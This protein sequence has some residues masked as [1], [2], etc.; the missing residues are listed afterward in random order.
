[1][2]ALQDGLVTEEQITEAC[3]RVFTTR[4]LL[5]MFDGSEYDAIPYTEVESPAHLA[6]AEKAAQESFVLLKNNGILP[7]EKS[8]IK[9]IGVIGPNANS[10]AAL[11]GNYHGTASRYV[12]I[13]EGLQDYLGEYVRVLTSTGCELFRDRT[14]NLAFPADRLSE[15]PPEHC[16]T[17]RQT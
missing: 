13:L 7:L 8:K 9:T 4:F 2:A 12:T 14:E 17:H 3:I 5:G 1:M 15:A 16:R 11:V 10:R 6:L